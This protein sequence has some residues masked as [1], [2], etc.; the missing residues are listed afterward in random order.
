MKLSKI[1]IFVLILLFVYHF[2]KQ[3]EVFTPDLSAAEFESRTIA[4]LN[5]MLSESPFD[6]TEPTVE[7]VLNEDLGVQVEPPE[8]KQEEVAPVEKKRRLILLT[9]PIN[10]GPCRTLESLVISR[11]KGEEGKKLGWSVGVEETNKLQVVD[12]NKDEEKFLDYLKKLNVFYKN[13][14]GI[15]VMF[16][17]DEDGN[18]DKS[19]IN[20][21]SMSMKEFGEYYNGILLKDNN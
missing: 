14:V 15:P 2:N 9:D 6:Q 16:I 8:Q 4:G 20:M 11:L 17:I 10:C 13:G 18:V 1:Q 12:R 5:V 19:S 3:K 7:S 21:G